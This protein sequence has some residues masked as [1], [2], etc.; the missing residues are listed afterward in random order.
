M[1]TRAQQKD[2]DPIQQLKT[3]V[4]RNQSKAVTR[5]HQPKLISGMLPMMKSDM[6]VIHT[7]DPCPNIPDSC[8]HE[9]ITS[10]TLPIP[11]LAVPNTV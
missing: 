3:P 7:I 9:S 11:K 4:A 8:A 1:I 5:L 2:K 6:H 10:T